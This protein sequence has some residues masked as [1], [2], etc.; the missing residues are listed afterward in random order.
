LS[1]LKH[2]KDGLGC[3]KVLTEVC[4]HEIR[5]NRTSRPHSRLALY[6]QLRDPL[7]DPVSSILCIQSSRN[8]RERPYGDDLESP[9]VQVG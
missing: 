6:H 4:S 1:D 2:R 5:L 8:G 9:L 7:P 3:F